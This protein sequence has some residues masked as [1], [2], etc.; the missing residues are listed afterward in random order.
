MSEKHLWHDVVS[1]QSRVGK[2]SKCRSSG[3]ETRLSRMG[4]RSDVGR[5][6]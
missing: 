5:D 1:L 4:D 3:N 6:Y 2:T